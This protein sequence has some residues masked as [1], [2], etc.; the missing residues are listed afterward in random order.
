MVLQKM[1]EILSFCDLSVDDGRFQK[2][3]HKS[4]ERVAA[5]SCKL[6]RTAGRTPRHWAT[7]PTHWSTGAQVS[8]AFWNLWC[9]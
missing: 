3:T 4:P 6:V 1:L 7:S 8:K 2:L 5:G 9:K